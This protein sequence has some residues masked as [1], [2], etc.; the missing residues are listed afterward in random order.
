MRHLNQLNEFDQDNGSGKIRNGTKMRQNVVNETG[1]VDRS[2]LSKTIVNSA[3][4][5]VDRVQTLT[6]G[7][8]FTT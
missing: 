6:I 5:D 8:Y 4:I 3:P 7:R 1:T 2:G